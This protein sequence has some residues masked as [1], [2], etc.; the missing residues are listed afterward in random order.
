MQ[1]WANYFQH[2]VAKHTFKR[3]DDIALW[4]LVRL[5]RTRYRWGWKDV[6]RQLTIPGGRW[7]PIAVGG[8]QLRNMSAISVTRY[9]YRGSKIPNPWAAV[10]A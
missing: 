2:A 1:G 4:R 6:R 10:N 5:L 3:L 7:Q 9:R 8:T